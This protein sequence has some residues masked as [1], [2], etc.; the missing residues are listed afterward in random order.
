LRGKVA[1]SNP[2]VGQIEGPTTQFGGCSWMEET[3]LH[4]TTAKNNTLSLL[5]RLQAMGRTT[6]GI[7]LDILQQE[8][9]NVIPSRND[10]WSE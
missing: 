1:F 5:Q 4:K 9:R 10:S 7:L 8:G 2:K 6:F 3:L